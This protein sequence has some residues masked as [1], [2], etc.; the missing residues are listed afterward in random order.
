MHLANLGLTDLILTK[1]LFHSTGISS[2]KDAQIRSFIEKVAKLES[3]M[4]STEPIKQ[5]LLQARGDCQKLHLHSQDLNQQIRNTTQELQRA[6]GELQQVPALRT[7]VD[8]LRAE[9]QR[10]R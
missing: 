7:E 9:L 5:E 10:A 8:N 2:E 1:Q 6:R 3:D 4:R